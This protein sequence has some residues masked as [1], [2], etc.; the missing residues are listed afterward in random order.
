MAPV[1]RVSWVVKEQSLVENASESLVS[2]SEDGHVL[3]WSISKVLESTQLMNLKRRSGKKEG[4]KKARAKP[5]QTHVSKP[6][7]QAAKTK[8]GQSYIS[9]HSPGIG[10]DF[11]PS[12]SNM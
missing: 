11:W 1:W 10:I 2:I 12:D 9:H 7:K 8:M 5:T 4:G 3:N 6:G